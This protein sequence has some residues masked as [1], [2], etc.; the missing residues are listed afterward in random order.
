MTR[1]DISN[2]DKAEVLA[3]L[4]N[5]ASPQGLGFLQYDSEPM[6]TDV[7]QELLS[8]STYFDYVRG[9]VMKVE[10]S[11][12]S[13]DPWL[14]D[15]DNGAGAAAKVIDAL[16]ETGM[17]NPE[18]VEV[19]S[20]ENTRKSAQELYDRLDETTTQEVVGATLIT[21]IGLD[22]VADVLAPKLEPFI[23]DDD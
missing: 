11:G 15:R 21:T 14:Y 9:R 7:A 12:D 5:G 20:L 16:N 2:L 17:V 1:I 4:Y 22:D 19:Q 23:D 3:A 8:K 18:E 13:F 10:L 6:G